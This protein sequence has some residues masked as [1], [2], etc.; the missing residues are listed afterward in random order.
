MNNEIT[1]QVEEQKGEQTRRIKTFFTCMPIQQTS[2]ELDEHGKVL[3]DSN[4]KKRILTKL[5]RQKYEAAVNERLDYD[6]TRFPVIPAINGYVEKGDMVHVVVIRNTNNN[7]SNIIFEEFFKEELE[8]VLEKKEIGADS[9]KITEIEMATDIDVVGNHRVFEQMVAAVGD[10]ED[11]HACITYG[12]KPSSW[13]LM[14]AINT[15]YSIRK[16][17]EIECIVYGYIDW[18]KKKADIVDITSLFYEG[19]LLTSMALMGSEDP[20]KQIQTIQSLEEDD[21]SL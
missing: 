16:G 12:T 8:N 4:G 14:T 21:S 2:Y 5:G 20:L 11:V 3:L 10:N 13:T 19:R 7:S 17:T 6:E 18:E 15:I 9:Y 1:N